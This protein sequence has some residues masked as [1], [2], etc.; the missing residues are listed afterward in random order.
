MQKWASTSNRIAKC[1]Y[2]SAVCL[3]WAHTDRPHLFIK[4][5]DITLNLTTLYMCP[6]S[7]ITFLSKNEFRKYHSLSDLSC[8]CLCV[9]Q[10]TPPRPLGRFT[11]FFWENVQHMPGSNINYISWP[12]VKGQGHQRSLKSLIAYKSV[13]ISGKNSCFSSKCAH[14][15]SLQL[16]SRHNWAIINPCRVTNK[17]VIVCL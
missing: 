4:E 16:C 1:Q 13:N 8:V 9:C 12:W 10:R 5:Y 14:L 17:N 2:Q 7:Y 6:Y 11:S 15:N 3:T